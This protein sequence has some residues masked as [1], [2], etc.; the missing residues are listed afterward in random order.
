MW[1]FV[2]N[3]RADVNK[4][5]FYDSVIKC[6]IFYAMSMQALCRATVYRYTMTVL[7]TNKVPF[8]RL[9]Y[10]C[11]LECLVMDFLLRVIS[12]FDVAS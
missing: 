12:V 3:I 10:C 5:C 7:H 8:A 1:L 4:Q 6:Y 11:L 9:F 2:H